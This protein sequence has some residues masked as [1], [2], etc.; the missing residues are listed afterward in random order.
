MS[1]AS[2]CDSDEAASSAEQPPADWKAVSTKQKVQEA[3]IAEPQ[4]RPIA[5]LILEVKEAAMSTGAWKEELD[6]PSW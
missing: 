2:S 5:E 1:P 6:E 3:A 4:D